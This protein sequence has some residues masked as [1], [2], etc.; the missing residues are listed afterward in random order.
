MMAKSVKAKVLISEKKDWMDSSDSDEEVNYALMANVEAEVS[1]SKKVPNVV[2]NFDT[3][4]MLELKSF[5]KNLHMSFKNQILEN[6]RLKL[7]NEELTKRNEHLETELV[8]MLD[9][10][11]EWERISIYKFNSVTKQGFLRRN[12]RKR[13]ILSEFGQTPVKEHKKFH[14]IIIVKKVLVIMLKQP[15][16][17]RE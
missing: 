12:S 1:S 17:L 14:M 15:K 3:N 11:K 13:R 8:C 7:S 4:N 6:D 9:L 10:Q 2:Y 16:K 5:L